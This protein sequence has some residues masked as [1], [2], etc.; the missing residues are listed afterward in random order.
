MLKSSPSK[1][2]MSIVAAAHLHYVYVVQG[3]W[4]PILTIQ[5]VGK[6]LDGIGGC[7]ME[8]HYHQCMP[9]QLCWS[10]IGDTK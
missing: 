9:L 8:Q 10:Y 6:K 5:W 4:L 2:N 7:L 3:L 1:C